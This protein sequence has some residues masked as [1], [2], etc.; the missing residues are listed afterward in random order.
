MHASQRYELEYL[1][2]RSMPGVSRR[3]VGDWLLRADRGATG[4]ANTVW[5]NGR[6]TGSTPEA[7]DE[8]EQ[9]Y[10]SRHLRAGFQIFNGSSPELITELDRRGYVEAPGAI[11]TV[12]EFDDLDL[13]TDQRTEG[14]LH[15]LGEPDPTPAFAELVSDP[16]RTQEMTSTSLPQWFLTIHSADGRTL[17]GGMATIDGAW[18]GVFAMKTAPEARRTGVA[19]R[20]LRDLVEHGRRRGASRIWLQVMHHNTPARRLYTDTGMSEA[21]RYHY[22]FAAR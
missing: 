2:D 4:R 1:S 19:H 15:S 18:L 14:P 3:R 20:V 12:A 9:W 13:T 7:I 17:G 22:R 11:V 21:H 10:E 8:V 5:P 16:D 6:P